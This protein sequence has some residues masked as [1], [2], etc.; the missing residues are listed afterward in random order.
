MVE[1]NNLTTLAKRL[2]PLLGSYVQN[3][4]GQLVGEGPGIDIVKSGNLNIIGL[5]GDT[6]LLYDNAG[7]PVAEF[8]T[9]TLALAAATSGQ[10]VETP[11]GTFTESFT[12]PTGVGLSSTGNNTIVSGTIILGGN[13]SF[14]RGIALSLTD[15]SAGTLIGIIGPPSGLAIVNDSSMEIINNGAGDAWGIETQNGNLITKNVYIEVT[16][17]G[18]GDSLGFVGNGAGDCHANNSIIYATAI[19]GG[20]AHDFT[21]ISGVGNIYA[22]DGEIRA[23]TSPVGI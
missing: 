2:R 23:T 20:H 10:L 14:L 11:P 13:N 9:I 8:A 17:N 1:Q 21:I 16:T 6:V 15:N 12:V 18:G 7:N 4:A 3:L 5:G 19:A 22:T